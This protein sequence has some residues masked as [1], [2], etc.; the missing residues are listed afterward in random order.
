M[1]TYY[2]HIIVSLLLGTLL[3]FSLFLHLDSLPLCL[4]DESRLAINA[5]E[6]SKSGSY[7]VTH[8]EGKPD[9]WNTKPPL[10][11]WIMAAFGTLFGFSDLIM[12]LPS[13]IAALLTIFA[14]IVLVKMIFRSWLLGIFCGIILTCAPGFVGYHVARTADYDSLMTLFTTLYC[15]MF[16]VYLH[17]E[18]SPKRYLLLAFLFIVLAT[19]TK[20]IAGLMPLI[21]IVV[22]LVLRKK[23]KK[24]LMNKSIWILAAIFIIV[25]GGYYLG[26]EY[27]NEGYLKIVYENELG[28]RFLTSLENHKEDTSFY[29]HNLVNKR[30]IS[31]MPILLLGII[32]AS[33]L[34]SCIE[35]ECIIYL[36]IVSTIHLLIISYAKTKL[37]W[38]DAPL[39]PLLA[40]IAGYGLHVIHTSFNA[41]INVSQHSIY[42]YAIPLCFL[43][44]PYYLIYKSSFNNPSYAMTNSNFDIAKFLKRITKSEFPH[45][46]FTVITSHYCPDVKFYIEGLKAQGMKVTAKHELQK[47]NIQDSLVIIPSHKKIQFQ[48]ALQQYHLADT[49]KN[50]LLF[51]RRNN[52]PKTSCY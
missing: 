14:V 13:A 4:W 25:I 10:V 18:S 32:A 31:F 39:F 51:Y 20:G 23:M 36:T 22:Y 24:I 5:I 49:L 26:R 11:I 30:F 3:Y 15:L 19:L 16:F 45:K 50:N 35:K 38:Y 48:S 6:M 42:K 7:L 33:T 29:L 37:E 46:N 44:F 8:F 1:K 40:I 43:L 27:Y 12:R 52:Q 41:S 2:P 28:G 17:L 34:K 21:G 47:I 9:I